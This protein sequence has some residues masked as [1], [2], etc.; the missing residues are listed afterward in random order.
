M[1]WI[2]EAL[3]KVPWLSRTLSFA[4][5]EE[6]FKLGGKPF[7]YDLLECLQ[8]QGVGRDPGSL[9]TLLLGYPWVSQ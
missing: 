3:E 7:K 4:V 5:S 8:S 6:A 1:Y 2:H 9:L